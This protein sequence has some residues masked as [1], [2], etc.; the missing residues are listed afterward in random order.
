MD[1][2]D[3]QNLL[4]RC[5]QQENPCITC[6]HTHVHVHAHSHI[7]RES[8]IVSEVPFTDTRIILRKDS[9]KDN[10]SKVFCLVNIVSVTFL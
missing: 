3:I 5:H 7:C 2:I 9:Q 4:V 6:K 10:P 1:A 8:Y